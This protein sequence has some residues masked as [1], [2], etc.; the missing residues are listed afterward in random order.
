MTAIGLSVMAL[1]TFASL[2]F[3]A[4]LGVY[5]VVAALRHAL[6][7][8]RTNQSPRAYTVMT[9]SAKL[10]VVRSRQFSM[11]SGLA[12]A[13]GCL[14]AVPYFLW[15][16]G[17]RRTAW[18]VIPLASGLMSP[19]LNY[20]SDM[21][22]PDG[23]AAKVITSFICLAFVVGCALVVGFTDNSALLRK[24]GR[25]GWTILRT[26]NAHTAQDA[27]GMVQAQQPPIRQKNVAKHR[28]N[29][30]WKRIF[31]TVAVIFAASCAWA[32]VAIALHLSSSSIF[33]PVSVLIGVLVTAGSFRLAKNREK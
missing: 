15:R 28:F 19:F 23:D 7:G 26:V 22:G 21:A 17:A 33:V 12:C 27:L 6:I 30:P 13:T 25:R 3:P 8:L 1:K 14:L 31:Y 32:G 24:Y 11:W 18:L 16:Y 29:L 9:R 4:A 10:K 20:S 2:W 5:L